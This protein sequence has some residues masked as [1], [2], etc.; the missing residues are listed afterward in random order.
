MKK[1]LH[2]LNGKMI[3]FA[4]N[5]LVQEKYV[6]VPLFHQPYVQVLSAEPLKKLSNGSGF[7]INN[8]S[9]L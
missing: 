9:H 3:D 8:K 4:V 6:L 7:I 1:N 5:N 2:I